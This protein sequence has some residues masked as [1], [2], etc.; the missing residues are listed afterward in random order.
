MHCTSE[1]SVTLTEP[2]T[3]AK[4][5]SLLTTRFGAWARTPRTSKVCGRRRISSGPRRSSRRARSSVKPSND[6]SGSGEGPDA[7]LAGARRRHGRGRRPRSFGILRPCFVVGPLIV[8][9]AATHPLPARSYPLMG[10]L[11]WRSHDDDRTHSYPRN[12][13]D[14]RGRPRRRAGRRRRGHGLEPGRDPGDRHPRERHAPGARTRRRAPGDARS[15]PGGEFARSW[16]ARCGRGRGGV[17]GPLAPDE[18]AG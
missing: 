4:S 11:A 1:S 12:G 7:P 10:R 5:A 18:R 13:R 8:R 3:E 16:R 9:T 15:A 2:Q 6:S 17:R 14:R